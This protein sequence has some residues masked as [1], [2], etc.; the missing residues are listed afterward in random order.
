[1]KRLGHWIKGISITLDK[2]AGFFIFSAMLLVVSNV[3]LRAV[4]NSP[5]KGTYE[6]VGLFTA[7][8]VGMGL[9]HC[10]YQDGHISVE[11]IMDVLSKRIQS[12]VHIFIHILSFCFWSFVVWHM[13]GYANE[14]MHNGLV[15]STSEVPIYPFIYLIALGLLVLCLVTL[16]KL[17]AECYTFLLSYSIKNKRLNKWNTSESVGEEII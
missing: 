1:M 3:L 15:T 4:F 13:F 10:A 9:A 12:I 5:I 14:T 8:A 16:K 2:I 17:V 6:L 11:F 7:V